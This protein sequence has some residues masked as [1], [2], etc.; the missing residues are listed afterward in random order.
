MPGGVLE[1]AYERWMMGRGPK[2]WEPHRR[3]VECPECGVEVAA[4]FL[5]THFQIQHGGG[6]G[7]W[8]GDPSLP[9]P[10]E[11][12]TYRVSFPKDLSKL[13]CPVAGCLGRAPF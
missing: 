8:G 7:D 9:P 2:F 11:A 12:Q 1:E 5:L 3:R 10:R 4:D 6:R 13:W